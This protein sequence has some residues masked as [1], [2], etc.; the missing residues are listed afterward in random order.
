MAAE[1]RHSDGSLIAWQPQPGP[2]VA[3]VTCPVFEVFY[4]GARYGGK[5]DGFLGD[6][7]IHA[8]IYGKHAHGVFLRRRARGLDQVVARGT[9]IFGKLGARWVGGATSA[10]VFPNGATLKI[11]HLWNAKDADLYQGHSYTRVYF[12]ELTHWPTPDAYLAMLATL[13]SPHGV[14][15]G[16]RSNANP[17]GLGHEWVKARFVSPAPL[18]YRVLNDEKTG[19]ERVFIPA[20]IEHNVIG[21]HGDPTYKERLRA[22]APVHLREAWMEGNWDI[23]P[24]GFFADVWNPDK[25]ILGAGRFDPKKIPATWRF[26]RSFDWGW[27]KPSSLGLW[28][29]S[30]GTAVPGCAVHFPRGSAVR[31][32]EWYTVRRQP[33]GLPEPN[34]GL[35]LNNDRLGAGIYERSKGRTWDGC[36]ADPSI[37]TAEGGKSIYEQLRDG[38]KKAGGGLL[39]SPADNAR[40]P[41]WARMHDLFEESAKERAESPGFWITERCT[42]FI[43][44]VPSLMSDEKDPDDI[45]TE[46]EDHTGDEARYLAMSLGKGLKRVQVEGR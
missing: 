22:T 9:E 2:Q 37:F 29:I 11:R 39:F 7:A 25:H 28:A 35:K 8:G 33:N 30:D 14:P 45:D 27:A 43:R 26:R 4:G 23:V 6:F 21:T 38:A 44:T 5:T 20:R 24:G 16:V 13:R 31:V 34:V 40:I 41:G 36:V 18:G 15:V 1:T 46:G 17:G 3:L 19:T 42:D 12:E 10:F 32:G